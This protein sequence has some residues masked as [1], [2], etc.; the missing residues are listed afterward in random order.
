MAPS[1]PLSE[2]C[3]YSLPVAV[4][5]QVAPSGGIVYNSDLTDAHFHVAAHP[6]HRPGSEIC[7]QRRIRRTPGAFR[8]QSL[9]PH[10][11]T[12][13]AKAALAP[14][15]ERGVCISAQLDDRS[16]CSGLQRA[17][18]DAAVTGYVTGLLCEKLWQFVVFKCRLNYLYPDRWDLSQDPQ[19]FTE[20]KCE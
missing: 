5:G 11:F 7:T 10:T 9:V 6:D 14:L 8:Q 2:N 19:R 20:K 18:E 17:G 3:C 16:S 15:P 1:H 12:K 13:C 4:P